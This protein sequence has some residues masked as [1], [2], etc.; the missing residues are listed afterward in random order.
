[1]G[2]RAYYKI[3]VFLALHIH[4]LTQEVNFHKICTKI[5][6]DAAESIQFVH[7]YHLYLNNILVLYGAV[8]NN[9]TSSEYSTSLQPYWHFAEMASAFE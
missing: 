7:R 6:S 9:T 2:A 5:I 4:T 3:F 8:D 1:M